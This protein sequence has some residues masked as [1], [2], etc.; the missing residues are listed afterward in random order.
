MTVGVVT[1]DGDGVRRARRSR[2]AACS[3]RLAVTEG[4]SVTLHGVDAVVDGAGPSS[5]G[6]TDVNV[7]V[8]RVDITLG[9]VTGTIAGG[10]GTRLAFTQAA[11]TKA[12]VVAVG[13]SLSLGSGKAQT[14][15]QSVLFVADGAC[16]C[17]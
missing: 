11:A 5:L 6:G 2:N 10:L 8:G 7:R 12:V 9:D 4:S 3:V 15:Q 17:R 16:E 1:K 13:C 14:G